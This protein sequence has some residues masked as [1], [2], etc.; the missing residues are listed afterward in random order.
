M[1]YITE[2][3]GLPKRTSA[4]HSVETISTRF[5][6]PSEDGRMIGHGGGH[7][8]ER[9]AASRAIAPLVDLPEIPLLASGCARWGQK[10]ESLALRREL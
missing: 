6:V 8:G 10:R 4:K 5:G 2:A 3:L 9:P 7:H 1:R